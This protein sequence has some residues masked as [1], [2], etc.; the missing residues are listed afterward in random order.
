MLYLDD[1]IVFSPDE[2][3]HLQRLDLVLGKIEEAGLKLKPS[4]CHFFQK[5]VKYLGHVVSN[6]GVQA[7]PAKIE[8]VLEWPVPTDRKKLQRFLGFAGYYRRFVKDFARIAGPLHELLK[9]DVNQKKG[10]GKRLSEKSKS[11]PLMFGV[12]PNKMHL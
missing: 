3:V 12:P 11:L 1:V 9:G 10:T 6:E 4:K 2:T 8:K 5:Q 7:D